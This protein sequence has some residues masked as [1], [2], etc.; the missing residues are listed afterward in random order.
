MERYKDKIFKGSVFPDAP[1]KNNVKIVF[2]KEMIEEYIPTIQKMKFKKG[3]MLL[4][5]IFAKKE[6]FFK[7]SRS[8]RTNNPGNIGNT[9]SGK[10]NGFASLEAGIIAQKLYF[11]RIV[12][13]LSKTYP[14]GK[15]VKI[16]PFYSKEIAENQ[17]TYGISPYVAGYE[18]VFTGQLD[19]VVKIYSTAARVG[20]SYLSEIIS[21]FEN[22]GIKINEKTTLSEILSIE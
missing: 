4:C 11:E 6:G 20:N 9:D 8:Y 12:N 10:N 3:L 19:Q 18:F 21:F 5:I 13:G 17:K 1:I 2:T 16:K 14:I 22:H 15:K 7:G